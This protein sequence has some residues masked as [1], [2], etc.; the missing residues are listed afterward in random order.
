MPSPSPVRHGQVVDEVDSPI[1]PRVQKVP[2]VERLIRRHRAFRLRLVKRLAHSSRVDQVLHNSPTPSSGGE[3]WWLYTKKLKA[4]SCTDGVLHAVSTLRLG[5]P[6]G[7]V[8]KLDGEFGD[9]RLDVAHKE[10]QVRPGSVGPLRSGDTR[11]API[12]DVAELDVREG[13]IPEV[14]ADLAEHPIGSPFQ[15]RQQWL[16]ARPSV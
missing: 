8:I 12:D 14:L 6:V 15:R 2:V 13:A 9:Q 7:R 10:V 3:C 16:S 11:W 1:G 4:V 5:R